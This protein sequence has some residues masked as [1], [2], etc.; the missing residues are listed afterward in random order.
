MRK[1]LL[2]TIIDQN[3]KFDEYILTQCKK[4]E[5]KLKALATVCTYLSLERRR[6]KMKAFIE[7][8]LA[9]CPLIWMLRQ[10]SSNTRIN[11]LQERALRIVLNDNESIFKDPLKKDNAV[12]IHRKNIP[13]LG[14][15]FYNVKNNLLT[16]LMCEIFNLRNID[17][18]LPSLSDFKEDPENTLR[19]V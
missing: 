13:L 15:D 7:S 5:R 9:Y 12:P 10:R 4:A 18:N 2:G 19:M 6:T 3:L 16:H 1:K 8:Q 17:Y 11:H 14:V